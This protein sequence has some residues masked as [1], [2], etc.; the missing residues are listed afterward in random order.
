[1]IFTELTSEEKNAFRDKAA[2]IFDEY[3]ESIGADVID[4][5]TKGYLED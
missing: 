4:L 1:M 3:R 2:G 5:F